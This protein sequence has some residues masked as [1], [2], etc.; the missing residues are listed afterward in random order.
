MYYPT[1]ALG[2]KIRGIFLFLK[3]AKKIALTS[4]NNPVSYVFRDNNK[5]LKLCLGYIII[6]IRNLNKFFSEIYQIKNMD[7]Y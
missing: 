2:Q 1:W 6:Y 4:K 7:I 5:N 3:E